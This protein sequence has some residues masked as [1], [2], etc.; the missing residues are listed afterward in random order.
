MGALLAPG[1]VCSWGRDQIGHA[2]DETIDVL[3]T[4]ERLADEDMQDGVAQIVAQCRRANGKTDDENEGRELYRIRN[5]LVHE[6]VPKLSGVILSWQ[7]FSER[8]WRIRTNAGQ[9][10]LLK[11][12]DLSQETAAL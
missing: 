10:V 9:A 4:L 8:Y 3:G 6:G 12:T 11:L 5:K 2:A 7:E 1:C